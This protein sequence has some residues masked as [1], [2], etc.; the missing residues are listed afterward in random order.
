MPLSSSHLQQGQ[1][2]QLLLAQLHRLEQVQWGLESLA[3]LGQELCQQM[4]APRQQVMEMGEPASVSRLSHH[5]NKVCYMHVG[6]SL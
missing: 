4:V 6:A 3:E 1:V 2:Q 5:L